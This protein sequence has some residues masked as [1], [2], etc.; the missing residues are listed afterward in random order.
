[1]RVHRRELN[2][3]YTHSGCAAAWRASLSSTSRFTSARRAWSSAADRFEP[4]PG[5]E[6]AGQY[7]R[8]KSC[9]EAVAMASQAS[10]LS[11]HPSRLLDDVARVGV[12]ERDD[13]GFGFS[14]IHFV[15]L[16]TTHSLT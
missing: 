14:M 6:A 12:L 1:M 11:T 7:A 8:T 13:L 5:S 10:L 9:R 2:V 16:F 4:P 3:R 15:Y